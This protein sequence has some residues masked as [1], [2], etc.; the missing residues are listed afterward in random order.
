MSFRRRKKDKGRKNDSTVRKEEYGKGRKESDSTIQK[1][2]DFVSME[3]S[4]ESKEGRHIRMDEEFVSM[5]YSA[6]RK[7]GRQ[8]H[9][10]G[11]RICK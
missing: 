6:E 11:G 1:K 5:E 2:E 8:R 9:K 3:Y 4:A 7:E 10:E